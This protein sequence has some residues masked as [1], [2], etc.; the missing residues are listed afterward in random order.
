VAELA[1]R[2]YGV[3]GRRQLL[4]LGL[5]D[6]AIDHGVATAR[7]YPLFRAAF[8]VGHARVGSH[9][10][11]LAAVLACGEG[12]VVSHGTAAFLL[13]LWD[14][15][16]GLINVI[17]PIESGRKIDGIRRRHVPPPAAGEVEIREGIP[18]TNPSRTLVDL[19]GDGGEQSLRRTVERAAV[20]K[21][22]DVSAVDAALAR[23]RRRGG[24]R[25]RMVLRDWRSLGDPV[26][27]RSDLEAR[28]LALILAD[29]L[30]A[31]SC[32]QVVKAGGRTMEVDFIWP[33][34]KLVVE[35]DGRRF[36]DHD[37]AFD[38]DR[39]RDRD[40]GQAGYQALRV[41]WKHLEQEPD[42][43]I[44]AIRARLAP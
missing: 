25:L 19:A 8:A 30:P 39:R 9:G 12:A 35:A 28:L 6:E 29:G 23:S 2:Q 24:P 42:E 10:R 44:A 7:L 5:S 20:L 41:T 37:L 17:A 3:V 21:V 1:G 38:R 15:P 26:R 40:L 11:M 16:P 22:L 36:H 33:D 18:C 27:L 14:R 34:R 13:G 4:E 31:P 43:T 32:N